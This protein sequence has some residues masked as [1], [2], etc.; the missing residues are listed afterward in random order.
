MSWR[1]RPYSDDSYHQPPVQMHFNFR[2]PS[3]AVKWLMIANVVIYFLDV[4]SQNYAPG[5]AHKLFGL[6]LVGIKH[7]FLWQP[8]TYM[9][10]HGSLMHLLFNMLGLY[11]FGSEFERAFSQKRFLQFYFVCGIVGGIAY[12]ALAI[13]NP[14]YSSIPLIGASGAVYGLLVAAVIFFPHIQVILFIFPMPIRVFALIIGGVLLLKLVSPGGV[15]NLGGE[16]CHIAGAV[17]GLIVFKTW[18]ILPKIGVGNSLPFMGAWEKHRQKRREGVWARKQKRLTAEQA[19]VDRILA[20]VH[21][22]GIQSLSKSEKNILA[23][24]TQKQRQQ[25]QRAGRIDRL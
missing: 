6:S 4:L 1:D 8:V 18:G 2:K 14:I 17:T 11:I 25:D 23:R 19:E 16:V 5:G 24:A 7:L 10:M 15:E 22:Q 9:F 12:L 3:S 21:D 13:I 20:K